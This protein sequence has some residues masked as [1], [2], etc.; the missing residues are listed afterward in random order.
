MVA[1]S[2][3]WKSPKRSRQATPTACI[4]GMSHTIYFANAH[5]LLQSTIVLNSRI[6]STEALAIV[7]VIDP[8]P[9]EALSGS[10]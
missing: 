4:K 2:R 6:F 9:Q 5:V 10:F 3:G 8:A 7:A 1:K